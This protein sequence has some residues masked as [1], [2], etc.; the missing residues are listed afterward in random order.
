M[1]RVRIPKYR[2]FKPRNLGLVV[3][4]GKQIYLGEYD[5]PDSWAEYRRLIQE[6]LANP[7]PP[8]PAED[9]SA[10]C[11]ISELIAAFWQQH[12]VTYY[13]KNG[14]PTSEQD[15]F[16]QA[17]RFLRPNYG[18]TPAQEFGPKALKAV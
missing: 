10:G 4:N 14:R 7:V 12:V 9:A 18:H 3:I 13:V 6:H 5:S 8:P 16:R 1:P 15:N 17:L 11:T 2:H